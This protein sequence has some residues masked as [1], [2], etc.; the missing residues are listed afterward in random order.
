MANK[1]KFNICN[2]HYALFDKTEEGV[3]KYKAPV[4]MLGAVSISL[5]PNGEPESFYA[6]GIEYYTISNNMGYDGDLKI[7]L[8]PESFRTDVLMEKADKN[9]ILVESSKSETANFALL[10]EF[11][12][13][14]KKIRH[15]M[16]NC[17]A[18]RPSL[19]GETNEESREVQPETIS[20][21]SRPLPNGNVKART[22]DEI[23]KETYDNWYK[24]VY[25]STEENTS[26]ANVRKAE[27]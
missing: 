6:D 23:T 20:I 9:K 8:I 11:D 15:I 14:Q 22:G 2:V 18:S 19:E 24:T 17:S 16:Y 5:E 26:P 21:Q 25:L 13:D 1:V 3:I 7:A 4:P 10:F 27:K 12:G